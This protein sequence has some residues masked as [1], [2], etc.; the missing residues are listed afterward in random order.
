MADATFWTDQALSW[1]ALGLMA[2]FERMNITR[3]EDSELPSFL[4]GAYHH[5]PDDKG[6]LDYSIDV[7][8]SLGYL[9]FDGDAMTVHPDG[10]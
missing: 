6:D 10:G 2:Y 8:L 7:L 3:I 1:G 9:Q 4:R 5:H